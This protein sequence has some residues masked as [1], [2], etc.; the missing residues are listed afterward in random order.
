LVT[1]EPTTVPSTLKVTVA[2][3]T[4][5]PPV[6]R[7]SVA[8]RLTGPPLPNDTEAGLGALNTKVVGTVIF[9][10]CVP[11]VLASYVMLTRVAPANSAVTL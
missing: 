1:P 10:V 8:E 4:T 3:T 11:L 5:A 2:P 9:S 6:V 7:V